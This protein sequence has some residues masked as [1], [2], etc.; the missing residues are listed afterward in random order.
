VEE[1]TEN[2]K[3]F[4]EYFGVNEQIPREFSISFKEVGEKKNF[5]QAKLNDLQLGDVIDDNTYKDD[6]YRYHDIFHYTFATLLGWSPCSRAMM[7]KKRKSKPSIDELEDGARAT[8]TEEAISLI[9]FNEAKRK[10]FFSNKKVNK[11]TLKMI[12]QLTE[13]FEVRIRTEKQWEQAIS[14]GYEMFRLLISNNGGKIYFNMN[15]R[16]VKYLPLI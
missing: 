9:L 3:F 8:I 6:F 7:K 12:K 13:N 10:H 16:S 2:I 11:S 5:V 4:D 14:K 15:K 1:L